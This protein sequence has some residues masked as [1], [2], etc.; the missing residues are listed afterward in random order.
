[1]NAID[2]GCSGVGVGV[3]VSVGGGVGLGVEVCVGSGLAVAVGEG[4]SVGVAVNV[5]TGDTVGCGLFCRALQDT[6]ER[7]ARISK[8]EMTTGDDRPEVMRGSGDKSY[9]FPA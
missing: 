1:M 5:G 4:G 8:N 7:I 9:S 6:S 3:G 2:M